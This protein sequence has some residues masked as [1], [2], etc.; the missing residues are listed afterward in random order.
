MKK[1]KYLIKG[2]I[3]FFLLIAFS[4]S[5]IKSQTTYYS[6]MSG[7]WNNLDTWTTDP[8]GTTLVGSQIPTD[9]DAVVILMSRTVTLASDIATTTLD[10][11]INSGGIIDIGS[12]S[13]TSGLTALRGEG[14]LMLSGTNFPSAATNT[15]IQSGGGTTEYNNSSNFTLPAAQTEYN[16]LTLNLSTTAIIATQVSNITLNGDLYVKSG[17]YQIN[18]ASANR[19]HLTINGDVTVDNGSTIRVG[20]GNT[21]T[22]ASV[23]GIVSVAAEPF[24]EYYDA[25][26][27]RVVV[28]GDF[29][30]NGTV[31]FT[32][33]NYPVFDAFPTDGAATVYFM[34]NTDNTLTCNNTTDFYNLVVDKGT[35]Q[36]YQLSVNS[37]DYYYFRLF[38][39]N[40]SGGENGGENPILKKALWIRNGTFRLFGKV[41]IPSLS[42]GACDP[43]LSGGPNSDFYI[44]A[45]AAFVV[46]GPDVIVLTTADD[47]REI[48]AAYNVSGGTG[49]VNGL[50]VGGCS[51]FSVYGKF[52]I[53]DG[54]ISTRESGGFIYWGN[55]SGEFIINGGT[56]DGKQLRTANSSGGLTAYRQTGGTLTLRGRLTQTVSGV[57]TVADLA[58]VP[59]NTTQTTNGINGD[60]GT[61]NID[62]DDNIFEMTGGTI[63]ILDVCGEDA[64]SISR[65][66]EVNSLPAYYSVSGGSVQIIPTDGSDTDYNYYIASSAPIYNL[67]ID[68][69]A[70]SGFDVLLTDIPAKSGVTART[71]PPLTV[72]NDLTFTNNATLDANN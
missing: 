38:G 16:N 59:L 48:N 29:T 33:Q 45:N 7:A 20:A 5:S 17:I 22:N 37:S 36:T 35:D 66:Y 58:T 40:I 24:V 32:N 13:F 39:A 44:P 12:Y 27:H 18:D 51:S 21:R 71:N 10:I 41:V 14:T 42:E 47:Y 60:L 26:T 2:L 11:T 63:E 25:N 28:Y 61:F 3:L 62:R 15:F 34:G 30:N 68:D 72:S 49:S 43:G 70:S 8:G 65:A 55:S 31:Q 64:S 1:N 6:Y 54:Y 9:G 67:T 69:A 4:I 52:Q 46:D 56:L 50:G 23:T 53:D 19:R 57:S